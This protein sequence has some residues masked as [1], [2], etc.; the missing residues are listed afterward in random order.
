MAESER[1]GFVAVVELAELLGNELLLHV[2]AG[3][4]A[5]TVRS[6]ARTPPQPGSSVRL[7]AN[8]AKLHWFDPETKL[9]LGD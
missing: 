9:R 4:H 2:K 5:M 8:T 7:Q 1:N 3:T 6:E